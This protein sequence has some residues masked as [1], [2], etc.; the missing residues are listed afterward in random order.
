[1]FLVQTFDMRLFKS[2]DGVS[3]RVFVIHK[4]IPV[5]TQHRLL[6]HLFHFVLILKTQY[7]EFFALFS[8]LL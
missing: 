4:V 6:S 3:F 1:M 7:V 8:W 2:Q 5:V